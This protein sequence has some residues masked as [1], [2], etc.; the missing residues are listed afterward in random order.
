MISKI[1]SR[2]KKSIPIEQFG[3]SNKFSDGLKRRCKSCEK[4]TR[5]LHTIRFSINGEIVVIKIN[6]FIYSLLK[7]NF[8]VSPG[9]KVKSI[10]K[11]WGEDPINKLKDLSKHHDTSI[12]KLV[13]II[14]IKHLLEYG[15]EII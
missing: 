5:A 11:N 15:I 9:I 7:I 10:L 1:C 12:V 2:C 13:E 6:P 3:K 8:P 14:I 4:V